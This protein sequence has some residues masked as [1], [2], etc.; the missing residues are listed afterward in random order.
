MFN[1][2]VNKHTPLTVSVPFKGYS[3][4][5]S[6][7]KVAI[8]AISSSV[9]RSLSWSLWFVD[10]WSEVAMSWLFEVDFERNC[11]YNGSPINDTDHIQYLIKKSFEQSNVTDLLLI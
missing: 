10:T 1:V 8:S 5:N 2:I 4:D 6:S 11:N 3:S 9:V 7:I